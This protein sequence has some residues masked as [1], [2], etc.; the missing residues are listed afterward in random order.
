LRRSEQKVYAPRLHRSAGSDPSLVAHSR[1]RKRVAVAL[2]A[3]QVLSS[4]THLIAKAAVTALGALPV[5]LLRFTIASIAFLVLGRLRGGWP[6][7]DRRDIPR[8]LL[9]GFLVVPINQGCFLFG[10]VRSTPSHASLLYAL[11]PLVV[12]ALAGRILREG[13]LRSK[14][15]GAGIAF[16][17]VVIILLERGLRQERQ[18]L[19]GDLFILV[20]VFAWALYTVLSKPLAER[21]G[22]FPVTGWAIISGTV[23]S[24]PAYLISGVLQPLGSI[25]PAVWAGILYLSIGTSL[26]AYP[27]W[28]YA[29]KHVEASKVA[30]T[31]NLQPILTAVLSWIIFR[32]RFTPG[33]LVGAV[34]VLGGITWV[35]TRK[36]GPAGAPGPAGARAP[37]GAPEGA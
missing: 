6:K 13:H 36:D 35:E 16:S 12:L 22:S 11:T 32:E 24:L 4:G 3:N 19:F 2:G 9:I 10:L 17:G 14:L 33:F 18:V 28:M 37:S 30:I 8:L 7:V 15:A 27:L 23:F 34:L 5:A 20:A 31:T 25:S 21:Y 1:R 26:V 29:L